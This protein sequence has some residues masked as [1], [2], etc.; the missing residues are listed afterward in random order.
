MPIACATVVEDNRS[1]ISVSITELLVLREGAPNEERLVFDR[2]IKRLNDALAS[3]EEYLRSIEGQ[4][5]QPERQQV[6]LAA[7]GV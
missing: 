3:D 6:A 2:I 7:P 1:K 5:I 4:T